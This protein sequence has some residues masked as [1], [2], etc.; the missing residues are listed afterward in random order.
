MKVTRKGKSNMSEML[1]MLGILGGWIALQAFILPRFGIHVTNNSSSLK[2]CKATFLQ[3]S[4]FMRLGD[5]R[6]GHLGR[7]WIGWQKSFP[8]KSR[9]SKST[10]MKSRRWPKPIT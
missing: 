4:I 2:S 3:S 6:V 7:F 8:V 1:I 10:A 9:L 5:R